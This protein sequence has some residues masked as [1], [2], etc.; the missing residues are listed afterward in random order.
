MKK[1]VKELRQSGQTIQFNSKMCGQGQ[2]L[3]VSVFAGI[4]QINQFLHD[5][6]V[7]QSGY[8]DLRLGILA[9]KHVAEKAS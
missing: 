1:F 2:H 5:V 8:S 6:V 4:D 9:G 3:E 7:S